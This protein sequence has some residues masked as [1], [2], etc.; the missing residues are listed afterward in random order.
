MQHSKDSMVSL[1]LQLRDQ[2]CAVALVQEPLLSNKGELVRTWRHIEAFSGGAC[3][4]AA[5]LS[6]GVDLW[7]CPRFSNRD[8]TTVL[9][10]F[11]DLSLYMTSVYLDGTLLSLP[12]CLEELLSTR[13]KPILIS[14]DTNAHSTL[15]GCS[16]S[17][18]RGE[19]LENFIFKHHLH[20]LNKGFTPTFITRRA[21]SIIDITLCSE[22]LAP[23]LADWKVSQEFHFSDHRQISF[24]LPLVLPVLPKIWCFKRADWSKF[25]KELDSLSESWSPPDSWS[26]NSLESEAGLLHKHLF[27]A[28]G[29]SCPKTRPGAPRSQKY[30]IWW[31]EDLSV[32]RCNVRRLERRARNSCSDA[33]HDLF[34]EARREFKREIASAKR[35]SWQLFTSEVDSSSRLAKLS[36]SLLKDKEAS[37]GLLSHQQVAA[38]SPTESVS[39]LFDVLFP[40]S[41]EQ[42]L[43][44]A[45]PRRPVPSHR[46]L[47]FLFTDAKVSKAFKSFGP[48]KAAGPDGIK[49]IMLQHVGPVTLR[50]IAALFTA[51][52]ELSFIPDLWTQAR[53]V[54]IPKVGKKD[55][56]QVKSFRPISLTSFML[57][58]MERVVL[59]T[60]EE[61]FLSRHP[62]HDRQHAF[63]GGRGTDSALSQ[64]CNFIE[65]SITRNQYSLGIFFD[66]VG[67]FS[68]VKFDPLLHSMNER[69][70]PR[71][72]TSWYSA[73]LT[74]QRVSASVKGVSVTRL[75]T[76]GTPQGGVLSPFAWNLV[77]DKLLDSLN[78]GPFLGIG[79]ADDGL[80]LCSGIDPQALADLAA[81][82]LQ[83][84]LNW[85]DRFGLQFCPVK[86]VAML[87][88]QKR[89]PLPSPSI[90]MGDQV[91]TFVQQTKYLGVTLTPSLE[92]KTHINDKIAKAKG[93][94]IRLRTAIG[95][96]WG[97]KPYLMDWAYK[98]IVL[99]A[100]T[101]ASSVWGSGNLAPFRPALTKLN[102]LAM[103]GLGPMRLK[104]PTAGLELITNTPPL[105]L[106]IKKLGMLTYNRLK[107]ILPVTWDG[108][109]ARRKMGH[110]RSWNDLVTRDKISLG[111]PDRGCR[112]YH[113][114]KLLPEQPSASWKDS[115]Q[116]H[117]VASSQGGSGC[118]SFGCK[119]LT[120]PAEMWSGF[121]GGDPAQPAILFLAYVIGRLLQAGH[122]E[123]C[124]V[125]DSLPG[126]LDVTITKVNSVGSVASALQTNPA[127]HVFWRR[128][129]KDDLPHL[130]DAAIASSNAVLRL[131]LESW[132]DPAANRRQAW[133]WLRKQ[134]TARW[135]KSIEYRQTKYWFSEPDRNLSA[136]LLQKSRDDFGL[137]AQFLT[138]HCWLR[139]HSHV[140][141]ESDD[142]TCRLC[143]VGPEEPFHL[144]SECPALQSERTLIL[145]SSHTSGEWTLRQLD[146]FLKLPTIRDLLGPPPEAVA[147]GVAGAASSAPSSPP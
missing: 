120:S 46:I 93:K 72:I 141:G 30:P 83:S 121:L 11:G 119:I 106:L 18:D 123:I 14:L 82:V 91:L 10:S 24:T 45:P 124:L 85:G 42:E 95:I 78:Q 80:L 114:R 43:P 113:W 57:K 62:F 131:E 110:V 105:D 19:L 89:K 13:D 37:L 44:P 115:L 25:E 100:L 23:L 79:Y 2:S 29:K 144:F 7:F 22:E 127:A 138:G 49:P 47:N 74:R 134:W 130:T 32:S 16:E 111:P 36:R 81:P 86:T 132:T 117:F 4:R 103:T 58:A 137:R 67:A 101:Y 50:R 8:V 99:P 75:L 48:Y 69:G 133:S 98:C 97:P 3:P 31:T 56:S 129:A 92:W 51:T 126:P 94:L 118:P 53:A 143:K 136:S 39:L 102:R 20:L 142:P 122:S 33:D 84:A 15:W 26:P 140:V 27:A 40:G 71:V 54:F 65:K 107:P 135:S 145:G 52:L 17:N 35:H 116:V 76:R 21:S 68:N 88:H 147:S 28:L 125:L 59:W 61:Y 73:Y 34:C 109:G 9:G 55:Y 64:C 12:A 112:T 87:F 139:R 108:L 146:R 104:T 38:S 41:V 128:T 1:Q 90:K 66:I 96:R 6:A 77:F 63:R 70:I 5:I 60:F